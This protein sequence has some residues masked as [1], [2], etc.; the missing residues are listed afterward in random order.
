MPAED[1]LAECA[2]ELDDLE[3]DFQTMSSTSS[4]RPCAP[5]RATSQNC[6][7]KPRLAKA[8]LRHV[9]QQTKR[10]LRRHVSRPSRNS[11]SSEVAIWAV[12]EQSD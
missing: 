2:F 11:K 5:V 10:Q 6:A 3:A 12:Y 7:G 4:R 9:S 8:V 1:M